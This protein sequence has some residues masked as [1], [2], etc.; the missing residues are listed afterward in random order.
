MLDSSQGV[1]VA[2]SPQDKTRQPRCQVI[3]TTADNQACSVI[4]SPQGSFVEAFTGK[5]SKHQKKENSSESPEGSVLR[6]GPMTL[7]L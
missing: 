5:N 6:K 3:Q 2:D 4:R 7:K 1:L